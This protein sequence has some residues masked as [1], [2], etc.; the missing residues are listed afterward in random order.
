VVTF[1][2]SF[3]WMDRERVAT[4]VRH[5]LGPDGAWVHTGATTH[6]GVCTDE[7]LP[8]PMPP[9]EEITS[10]VER[11]LGP[12]RRTGV[13]GEEDVMAAAGYRGPVRIEVGGGRVFERTDDDVVAS[14]YSL[15]YAAPH[16]F[17]ERLGEFEAE[18]RALLRSVSPTGVFSERQREVELVIWRP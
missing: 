4:V 14:V 3:H 12:V 16:L 17:G 18:L 9:H 1:A 7:G 13:S 8:W 6:R 2:Q 10:L 5:L 15:S 11:Y